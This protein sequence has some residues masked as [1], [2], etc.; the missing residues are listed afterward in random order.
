MKKLRLGVVG[1]GHRGSAMFECVSKEN[2]GMEAVAACDLNP[3]LWFKEAVLASG[4][5]NEPL[6]KAG[7]ITCTSARQVCRFLKIPLTH[8]AQIEKNNDFLILSLTS[9]CNIYIIQHDTGRVL[10]HEND[11]ELPKCIRI[12]QYKNETTPD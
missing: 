8:Y 12:S 7:E 9:I 5:R 11:T 4:C 10:K 3:D 1:L 6:A 2:Q